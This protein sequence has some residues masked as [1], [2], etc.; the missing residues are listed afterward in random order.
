MCCLS[1][2]LTCRNTQIRASEDLL[3]LTKSLK[4]AWIFGQIGGDEEV[5][6]KLLAEADGDAAV[7]GEKLVER[8]TR[9]MVGPGA[10]AAATTAPGAVDGMES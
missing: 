5:V 9:E 10:A 1:K 7:V 6:Q 4:E 3:A 2:R 8:A